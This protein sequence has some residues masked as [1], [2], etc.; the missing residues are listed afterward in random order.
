MPTDMIDGVDTLTK[1]RLMEAGVYDVQNLATANPVLLYVE[2]PFNLMTILDWI[3]QAQLIVA[4]GP[5]VAAKLRDIGVRTVFEITAMGQDEL[6]RQMV[7]E[8]V[9]PDFR[10][11]GV[12]GQTTAQHYD[13]L[14][15]KVTGSIHARR[16]QRFWSVMIS[17]VD[18]DPLD[19]AKEVDARTAALNQKIWQRETDRATKKA[20]PAST[21]TPPSHQQNTVRTPEVSTTPKALSPADPV[22]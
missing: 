22:A 6:T 20:D 21:A 12:S 14:V 9:W 8:K 17:L 1:F 16:L 18:P 7:L 5:N 13:V 10:S 2:T 4:L 15:T 11:L 19:L 3:A